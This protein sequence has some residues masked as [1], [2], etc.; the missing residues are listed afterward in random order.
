MQITTIIAVG[1]IIKASN[2]VFQPEK[3]AALKGEGL[4][5]SLLYSLL[6]YCY[7]SLDLELFTCTPIH[8]IL[9]R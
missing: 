9:C 6:I 3:S 1:Y 4:T 5:V 2:C 7:F 8:V